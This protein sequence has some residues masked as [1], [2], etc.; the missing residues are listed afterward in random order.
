MN[1]YCYVGL[2]GSGK[3]WHAKNDQKKLGGI[4]VDDCM[5]V[6]IVMEA[7]RQRPENI[8]ITDPYFCNSKVRD[9]AG[10][11]IERLYSK[12]TVYW[13]FFENDVEKCWKNILHRNDEREV[14]KESVSYFSQKYS[15]PDDAMPL[16]IWNSDK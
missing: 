12:A 5:D 1:V 2:P 15:I 14:S 11:I 7:I 6:E 10:E 13:V 16:T 3:T 9:C 4:L 8:F